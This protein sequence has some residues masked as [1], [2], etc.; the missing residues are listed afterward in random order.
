MD[1][2]TQSEKTQSS[3]SNPEYLWKLATFY[4]TKHVLTNPEEWVLQRSYSLFDRKS[5][6]SETNKRKTNKTVLT[7]KNAFKWFIG[8]RIILNKFSKYLDKTNNERQ[9]TKLWA[10]VKAGKCTALNAHIKK[11]KKKKGKPMS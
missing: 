6:K 9:H 4:S 2:T 11:F 8:Q 3:Q 5:G 7:L 10:V 1:W